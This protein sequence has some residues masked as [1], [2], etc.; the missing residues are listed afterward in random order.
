MPR[1]EKDNFSMA[2]S[3]T[4]IQSGEGF[5]V[6]LWL[7]IT[8]NGKPF[9]NTTIE[10]FDMPGEGVDM[11]ESIIEDVV[12]QPGPSFSFT[13]LSERK[14]LKLEKGLVNMLNDLNTMGETL[15]GLTRDEKRGRSKQLLKTKGVKT[16]HS[17]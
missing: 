7:N 9:C 3:I 10:Y 17:R 12:G 5:N 6:T 2:G 1:P 16:K 11:Y 15:V 8:D 13:G 4:P 14:M